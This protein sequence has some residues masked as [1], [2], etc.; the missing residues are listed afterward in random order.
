QIAGILRKKGLSVFYD[1]FYRSELW[2]K[3]L[4]TWFKKKYGKSSCFVLVLISHHYPVKDWADFEFSIAKAEEKK[5][6]SE[7]ILPVRLD[8]TKLAGL[9]SDKVYLDLSKEGVN[10]IVDCIV[11]KVKAVASQ[12]SSKQLFRK[13]Y[14]E[15]KI[16]G[17]LPGE[18]KVRYFLDNLREISLDVDSCEFLL[19][20]ITGYYQNLQKKL[21]GINKQILFDASKQ[22]LDKKESYY[23]KWCGIRYLVF[24]YPKQAE[25]YLWNIYKD[26]NEDLG[27]RM[28]AFKRLWKCESKKGMDESYSIVLKEPKWQLRQAAIKNIRH[29]K[30]RK[31]TSKL[32][33]EALRDKRWEVR[34]EAAYAI[35]EFKLDELV[36]DMVNAMENER[37]RKGANRLLYCLWN[38]NNHSSVKDFMK[39]YALPKWFYKTPDYHTVWEDTMD[40]IL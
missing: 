3:R 6:K 14:R 9:A 1:Q 35:V 16:E 39:K 22:M 21:S 7:F 40:E 10:G 5:R 2:G 25:I 33:L 15:W 30:V 37:S 11:E 27:I 17:F 24:A 34:T 31:E 36:P 26:D 13:A 38:F 20:S 18:A 32:L 23:T 19:R 12:K 28:E 8:K 4:S 29:G